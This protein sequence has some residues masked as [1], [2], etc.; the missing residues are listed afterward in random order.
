MQ[1]EEE[2]LA[3]IQAAVAERY[4]AAIAG[5][6]VCETL[7]ASAEAF[8]VLVVACVRWLCAFLDIQAQYDPPNH[9]APGLLQTFVS[10]ACVAG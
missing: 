4:A 3:R 2:A 8:P 1:L 9:R 5:Q 6:E 10:R 7:I